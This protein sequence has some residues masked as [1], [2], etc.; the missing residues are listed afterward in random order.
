MTCILVLLTGC[1]TN[2]NKENENKT[3]ENQTS[4]EVVNSIKNS[5][6]TDFEELYNN[7]I[8]I[9]V[10]F[11]TQLISFGSTRNV[12]IKDCRMIS[13]ILTMIGKAEL[14][15]DESSIKNM[16]GMA[17]KNNKMIFIQQTVNK[18]EIVFAFD[19]PAF[20]VGYIEID[21][22]KYNPKYD[23]FRY[24]R[25]FMEYNH[26]N[27][28]IDN[29][30]EEMF[31][32]Y[33]WTTDYI[34]NNIEETLP[35]SFKHKAGEYPVKIYWAYNNELSKSI[36][37]DYSQYLGKKI[38][39]EI[40]RLRE[41]LPENMH[42]RMDARGIVLKLDN[43]II[44]AYIDAGRHDSFACSLD[45]KI[46]KEITGKDWDSWIADYID[47]SDEVENKLSAMN[48]EEIIKQYYNALDCNEQKIQY[49]CLTR[50]NLCRYLASNMDN[51]V[52][53]NKDYSTVFGDG[54]QNVKSAKLIDLE[55]MKEIDNPEGITKYVV[56]IDFEFN[57]EITSC[58]G[59]QPRFIILKKE[60]DRSGWRIDSE[61]TGP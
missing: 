19:D 7:T 46:L 4:M 11:D 9:E 54:D 48:P 43:K 3:V 16:S 25:D 15:T 56:T 37:L 61:G 30:T 12:K 41:S 50:Q 33:G 51:N 2:T 40:L 6:I 32:K 45:R 14:I 52:L 49:A 13:D 55:E 31:K 59:K 42:P 24:I 35:T 8:E 60:S 10:N 5:V 36:G 18:K 21:G 39:V 23:F 22:K 58:N 44:G 34:I 26:F 17:A 53:F 29:Q 47:Y 28:E 38:D 27:S 1:V 20:E 57:K